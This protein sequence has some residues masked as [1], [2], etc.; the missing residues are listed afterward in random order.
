MF[1]ARATANARYEIVE[2]HKVL[3]IALGRESAEAI[4]EALNARFGPGE[5]LGLFEPAA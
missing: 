5:Q 2:G 3:A 4:V 1:S